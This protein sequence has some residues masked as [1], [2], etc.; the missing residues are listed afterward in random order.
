MPEYKTSPLIFT[1][2]IPFVERKPISFSSI[3]KKEDI[4][5]VRHYLNEYLY[6]DCKIATKD[7][8]TTTLTLIGLKTPNLIL[9]SID[10][11]KFI[12]FN[13]GRPSGY[14]RIGYR[15]GSGAFNSVVTAKP[16]RVPFKPVRK[17]L[18]IEKFIQ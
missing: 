5:K 8:S 7:L 6:V 14:L 12:A 10:E 13:M 4:L 3:Y 11:N 1:P 15:P 2:Q 16:A 17:M 9:F 18:L